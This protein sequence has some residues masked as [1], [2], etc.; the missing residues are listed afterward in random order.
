MSVEA[1]MRPITPRRKLLIPMLALLLSIGIG[2]LI[3]Y[4]YKLPPKVY[5]EDG[6]IDLGVLSP[7]DGSRS[8][9]VTI[10][11][12]GLGRLVMKFLASSCGC[13][14]ITHID[15]PIPGLRTG[16]V[17]LRINPAESGEGYR[18]QQLLLATNDPEHP[19]LPI[20]VAWRT[21][22]ARVEVSP[23]RIEAE[24]L[25]RDVER[26][27][28]RT[29]HDIMV[30]DTAR[31]RLTLNNLQTSANIKGSVEEVVHSC[32]GSSETHVFLI[33]TQ[34]S[35]ALQ[36]GEYP[37]WIRFSTSDPQH[38]IITVPIRVRV[39]GPVYAEPA[40][41]LLQYDSATTH[42]VRTVRI[43]TYE[44]GQPIVISAVSA[45]APWLK[46]QLSPAEQ[47][48]GCITVSVHPQQIGAHTAQRTW[49]SHINVELAQPVR[50][51]LSIP[52]LLSFVAPNIVN[53]G[54]GNAIDTAHS[55]MNGQ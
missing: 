1:F 50:C 27:S 46:V 18:A 7:D 44:I 6:I 15:S 55:V 45:D 32:P 31:E 13:T 53:G 19:T 52:V 51:T 48:E 54:G 29:R 3:G 17:V 42:P 22:A 20:R 33:H 37:E 9:P 5:V 39:K 12:R 30:V 34:L 36:P 24:L 10:R 16:Q 2:F 21:R 49:E 47:N 40:S 14:T 11:N 35:Q 25:F 38:P 8:Y 23:S 43:K 4:L 26:S 41:L 28:P